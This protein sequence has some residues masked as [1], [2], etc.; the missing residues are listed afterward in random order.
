MTND[1]V[2]NEV[3]TYQRLFD[4]R[5]TFERSLLYGRAGKRLANDPLQSQGSLTLN[6]DHNL[7]FA[8]NSGGETFPAFVCCVAILYSWIK[9]PRAAPS[10]IVAEHNDTVY[11]L[12]A[13]GDG[14][15][16]AYR[17]QFGRL[18]QIRTST[19][20]LTATHSGGSS[21]SV[22]AGWQNARCHREGAQQ[23][24][25][26]SHHPDGTWDRLS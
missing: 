14:A 18:Q 6:D 3:L 20:H 22:Q 24:R 1:A 9:N 13:G 7:L 8:I 21:I 10:G 17:E 4:G 19:V 23:Y 15:I 26:L 16:V 5:L 2:K 11:V 25:Y 12:D